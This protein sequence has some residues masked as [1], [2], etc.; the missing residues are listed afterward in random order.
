[1]IENE[2]PNTVNVKNKDNSQTHKNNLQTNKKNGE[3]RKKSRA[4]TA[5]FLP[6]FNNKK[7][8]GLFFG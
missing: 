7:I 5:K 6:I 8:R 1:L 3:F 4:Q 2:L